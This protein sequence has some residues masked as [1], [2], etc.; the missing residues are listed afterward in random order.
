MKKICFACMFVFCF[1]FPVELFLNF[2]LKMRQSRGLTSRIGWI[3]PTMYNNYWHLTSQFISLQIHVT[4]AC[5]ESSDKLTSTRLTTLK[6][7]G[8]K[9]SLEK[10]K[11]SYCKEKGYE[12]TTPHN[13]LSKCPNKI[14]DIEMEIREDER[15]VPKVFVMNLLTNREIFRYVIAILLFLV[16]SASFVYGLSLSVQ[17][18]AIV[19]EVVGCV[20]G[21]GG[22]SLIGIRFYFNPIADRAIIDQVTTPLIAR[23]N[24][25]DFE[26]A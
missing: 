7:V 21:V 16:G 10:P 8:W 3:F 11:C 25:T 12:Q 22:L 26:D 13:F 6:T 4:R 5:R 18:S 23:D 9:T 1:Q 19:A 17:K 24:T 20:F 14:R 2:P 15:G